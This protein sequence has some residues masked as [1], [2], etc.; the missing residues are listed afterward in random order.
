M[1]A[2]YQDSLNKYIDENL[3]FRPWIIRLYNQ[4]KWSVFHTTKSPGVVVGK[5]GYL[6]IESYINDY[7]GSNFQGDALL[8]EN[9]RKIKAVQDT[10]KRYNVD[11]IIV[12][13][14]GKASYYPEY[15]PDFYMNKKQD[16]TNYKYYAEA[17]KNN[18]INVLDMNPV[19]SGMKANTPYPLYPK[20]GTH[21][22]SYGV[23]LF[24]DTL[25]KYIEKLRKIDL[26]EIDYHEIIQSDS[27]R[28]TDNDVADLLNIIQDL[29]HDPMPYPVLRYTTE[30]KTRPSVLAVGDSYWWSVVGADIPKN[31]FKEDEYWFYNKDVYKNN[32]KQD[33]PVAEL[34]FKQETINRD[35]II[36][37]AA[38][39]TQHLFPFGFIDRAYNTYCV[40]KEERLRQLQNE[41]KSNPDWMKQIQEKAKKNNITEEQQVK[42]DA[43]YMYGVETEEK[44]KIAQSRDKAIADMKTRIRNTPEWLE[45]IKEKAK[46]NGISIDEQVN[47]DAEYMYNLEHPGK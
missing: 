18:G 1:D 37:M 30:N 26:P 6:Y 7:T 33:K 42:D 45:Q 4:L 34:S 14:Q 29:P 9:V 47:R 39:A 32:I 46:N 16:K 2:T 5:D 27:L 20:H 19:F 43:A 15:I 41:I 10:L 28:N 23:A 13:G 40:T 35:V 31:V 17:F 12:M 22:T 36:V 44:N 24:A 11:L 8:A 38:E 25:V 3:G 21:W